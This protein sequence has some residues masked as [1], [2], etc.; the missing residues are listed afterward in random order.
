MTQTK[1]HIVYHIFPRLRGSKI[2]FFKVW[3]AFIA[4]LIQ[5]SAKFFCLLLIGLTAWISRRVYT[6]IFGVNPLIVKKRQ[7][8]KYHIKACKHT[9]L[10][11]SAGIFKK[12]TN[13]FINL[14]YFW[15]GEYLKKRS[16]STGSCLTG[17]CSKVPEFC[18]LC[19]GFFHHFL[20]VTVMKREPIRNWQPV[21]LKAKHTWRWLVPWCG[22]QG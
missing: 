19:C 22:Q 3:Y 2:I 7:H 15:Q 8:G 13:C 20:P 16:I 18:L 9:L 11:I 17:A 10:P 1:G 4:G 21:L 5:K 6:D 12:L 14:L